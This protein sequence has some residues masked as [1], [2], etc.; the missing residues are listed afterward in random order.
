MAFMLKG[1]PPILSLSGGFLNPSGKSVEHFL[2]GDMLLIFTLAKTLWTALADIPWDFMAFIILDAAHILL[3][4]I[5]LHTHNMFFSMPSLYLKLPIPILWVF[6]ILQF[7]LI[8]QKHR[9]HLTIISL[10]ATKGSSE[11][12]PFNMLIFLLSANLPP[13]E[14]G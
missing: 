12:Q 5:P 9:Q 14:C 8:F 7:R 13:H 2:N 4:L 10:T 3:H 11:E 6:F 1:I